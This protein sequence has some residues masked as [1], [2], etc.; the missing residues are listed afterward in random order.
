MGIITEHLFVEWLCIWLKMWLC[1]WLKIGMVMG[2][3]L[4]N[5]N[6]TLFLVIIAV[7]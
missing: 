3:N 7:S 5:P 2:L 6:L 4:S 1:I